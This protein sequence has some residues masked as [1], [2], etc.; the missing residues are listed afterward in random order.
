LHKTLHRGQLVDFDLTRNGVQVIIDWVVAYFTPNTPKHGHSTVQDALRGAQA[1]VS[2]ERMPLILQHAGHSRTIIG[3]EIVKGAKGKDNT[4]NLLL[5]DPSKRPPT[6]LREVALG[7]T[8]R[9]GSGQPHPD[10]TSKSHTSRLSHSPSSS[11][12]KSV[13]R[14][15]SPSRLL[16]KV[17]KAAHSA[18]THSPLGMRKRKPSG[19]ENGVEVEVVNGTGSAVQPEVV[20]VDTLPSSGHQRP[21]R[22]PASKRRRSD[23]DSNIRGRLGSVEGNTITPVPGSSRTRSADAVDDGDEDDDIICLNVP[24]VATGSFRPP[25]GHATVDVDLSPAKVLSLF[26]LNPKQLG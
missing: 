8:S 18:H 4:I 10:D 14:H 26:R 24:P 13:S 16:H 9:T 12:L 20:D 1:I 21:A 23:S 22:P 17:G 25:P 5:F 19:Q 6:E 3:Y 7:T 15:M 2:T 11:P